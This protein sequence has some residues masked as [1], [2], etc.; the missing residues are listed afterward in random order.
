ME[1]ILKLSTN[2]IIKLLFE[3][4][5]YYFTV[6]ELAGLL[7]V[8]IEKAY[9]IVSRLEGSGFIKS[10]ERGKYLLLG[11]EPERVLSNPFFIASRIVY[12]SY[13]SFWSAL[14]F[15]GFT[16][17]VPAMV[18]LASVRKKTEV[19]F[20]SLRFKYVLMNP[21]KFFGYRKE[22]LGDL[23]FLIAEEEKAIVDSLYLPEN[24]GGLVE[25][26]KA[27]YNARDKVDLEKLFSYA[28]DMKSRSLSSRLGYLLSRFGTDAAMLL[29][30]SASEYIKLDPTREKSRIWDKKWHVN[31]NLGEEEISGWRET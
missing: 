31:V 18:L 4:E 1:N 30:S 3:Q 6:R 17:Q 7:K 20:N 22:K 16:E 15:Y 21:G 5:Y 29:E 23:D 24:A 14:N 28:I 8:P 13:V 10:V 19:E 25:V 11:F 9:A 2:Y 12:P 27:V 26:A